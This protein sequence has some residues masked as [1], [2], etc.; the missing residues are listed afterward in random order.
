MPSIMVNWSPNP[1]EEEISSYSVHMDGALV[2]STP[3]P[4]FEI[5]E[6]TPGVHVIEIAAVNAWGP[7]PGSDPVRTPVA[8]SKPG[9]VVISIVINVTVDQ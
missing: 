7:G 1:P 9:G 4:S 2:G 3:A 8:P 5:P 6:V